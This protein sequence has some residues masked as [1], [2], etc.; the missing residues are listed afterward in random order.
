M[1]VVVSGVEFCRTWSGDVGDADGGGGGGGGVDDNDNDDDDDD[2]DAEIDRGANAGRGGGIG[3]DIGA[4]DA[5]ADFVTS[6]TDFGGLGAGTG[7]DF[8]VDNVG[9]GGSAAGVA[10][11]A[12]NAGSIAGA[13]SAGGK[14]GAGGAGGG[15]GVGLSATPSATSMTLRGGE[16]TSTTLCCVMLSF[17][18]YEDGVLSAE[19]SLDRSPLLV[20]PLR[21]PSI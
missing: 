6:E 17:L 3:T 5:G 15:G 21:A 10:F 1:E 20:S 11:G 18:E 13:S 7:T 12:S 16:C 4:G 9:V 14:T 8:C 19:E 2:K